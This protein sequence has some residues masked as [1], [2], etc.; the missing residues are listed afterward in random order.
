MADTLITDRRTPTATY[1]ILRKLGKGGMA[2]VF[3]ARQE[4]IAGFRRLAV[5]KK[6]L[7]QFSAVSNVAEMLLDEARI[8]A[9][10]N[11]PNIV[12][13]YELGKEDGQYFI[14]MEYVDGCDLATLARIE[15]HK[16]AR[17]PM[18]LALRV[19]S[20]A[21]M[22][23]DYAH[24]Q[25]GLDGRPL[26]VVHRDVSPHNILCSREGA[27][28]LTDFGIAKAVGKVQVTEVGVVKGKVQYMAPEQ[29]TGG[30]VDNRSD[31]FSL[32]VVLYQLTTGRLPRVTKSGN[33]AMRRVLEGKIPRP[34]EIRT[35]YPEELE[36]VVMRSLAHNPDE[37]YP[38]AASF[39]D[40]LLDFA[41]QND[42]LAFPKELGDYV[43]QL[44][45][46]TPLFT[47]DEESGT[48]VRLPRPEPSVIV[49]DHAD[50]DPPEGTEVASP[51]GMAVPTGA[52]ES[53]ESMERRDRGDRGE[54]GDRGDRGERGER[55]ERADRAK[56]RS[57]P[58][59]TQ[60]VDERA[61]LSHESLTPAAIPP[62]RRV[63]EPIDDRGRDEAEDSRRARRSERH[64]AVVPERGSAK[65]S[66]GA[67]RRREAASSG[68]NGHHEESGQRA[69]T[70][71]T[72]V[73]KS[74]GPSGPPPRRHLGLWVGL[75]AGAL[76]LG[77][78]G[79]VA[80]RHPEVFGRNVPVTQPGTGSATAEPK[81]QGAGV[82]DIMANPASTAV[83]VD[84]AQRCSSTPC[85]IEGLPLGRELL[86]TLRSPGHDLWMQRLVLTPN[87][88][89]LLL[90][91]DLTPSGR[92]GGAGV[93]KEGGAPVE[94]GGSSGS[95]A[96]KVGKSGKTSK[97]SK[98]VKTGGTPKAPEGGAAAGG[99]A[100]KGSAPSTKPQKGTG[101]VTVVD[102]DVADI[103]MLVV[104]VKPAWAEVSIDGQKAGHT[105][106]QIKIEP[107]KHTIELKNS[108][109]N[110]HRV[111]KI[112]AK[113]GKK[114]KISDTIQQPGG[115]QPPG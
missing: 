91:A 48:P 100:G 77:A 62:G 1:R 22:G 101:I 105:P 87:D 24:R 115:G 35:D 88:P 15:R 43:N 110:Y 9:Q 7:P 113:I 17:V 33:V 86:I 60:E 29:Y 109:L 66:N 90:R 23:L 46:P 103:S 36:A 13:I 107:G 114:V 85:R 14:A 30:E 59:D 99:E 63:A 5:I 12:Q 61:V 70:Q 104:D 49:A 112:K 25:V 27:V 38:D 81:V 58:S 47:K 108:E 52:R 102:S 97:G 74:V 11:H 42:L 96:D 40:D 10:L 65:G 19:V 72:S 16:N 84:G 56:H 94:K 64:R 53:L 21:A 92:P 93:P 2:E 79:F 32:G 41:R 26:N 98:G 80:W 111:Y 78:A 68:S 57:V 73:P 51:F 20:E 37:R 34:T 4:G 106:L 55:G 45:P 3:L 50:T 67:S 75:A 28:K 39:R 83:S 18:R 8:A 54:R 89:R 76:G 71:R 82:V 44:V 31:I 95:A 6:I 69:V